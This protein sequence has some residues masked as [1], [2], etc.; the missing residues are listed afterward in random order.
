MFI[1][2]INSIC[3]LKIDGQIITYADDICLLF[4]GVSWKDVRLKAAK[5]FKKV[6]NYLNHRKLSINYKKTN[7]INFSINIDENNHD[8]LKLCFCGN[9]DNCNDSM[10]HVS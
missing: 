2:Y 7:F 10:S 4:S 8:D 1:L 3:D 5:E 9:V 6:I